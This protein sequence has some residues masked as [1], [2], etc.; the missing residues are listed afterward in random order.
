MI[1]ILIIED[2]AAVRDVMSRALRM[3]GYEVH[4]AKDGAEGLA[5]WDAVHPDA[6]VTDLHMP[7]VDGIETIMALRS[8]DP[9]VRIVAV[10]GGDS[11]ASFLALDSAGDLGATRVL[12]KPFRPDELAEAVRSVLDGGGAT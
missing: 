3:R 11:R 2:E 12:P 10:S 4:L 6:V 5:L 8:R 7:N 9:N 1:Q